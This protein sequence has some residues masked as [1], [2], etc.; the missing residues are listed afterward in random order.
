MAQ[1]GITESM[2]KKIIG[3]L[4]TSAEEQARTDDEGS[5]KQA[6]LSKIESL[7]DKMLPEV[8]Y[9]MGI[10]MVKEKTMY[11]YAI[12]LTVIQPDGRMACDNRDARKSELLN[13]WR[14]Q[15][16]KRDGYKC[17]ECGSRKQIHAHHII[18]WS[19]DSKKRFDISN[20]V[21]LCAECH[22]TKH[23]EISNLIK[24][25]KGTNHGNNKTDNK[26][27]QDTV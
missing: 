5:F 22:S 3:F 21:A 20:G 24:S 15:V 25:S 23:P 6:I 9:G 18:A 11:G 8:G 12:H 27:V 19:T 2:Q 7:L 10:G 26:K 13:E 17:Q 4:L 16:F 14:K 1:V